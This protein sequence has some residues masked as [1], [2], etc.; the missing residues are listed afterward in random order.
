M[1]IMIATGRAGDLILGL[2]CSG[3]TSATEITG[4]CESY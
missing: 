3:L 4:K 1:V 2:N